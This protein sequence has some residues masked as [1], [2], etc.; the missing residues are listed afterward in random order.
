MITLILEENISEDLKIII[1]IWKIT[2]FQWFSNEVVGW[3]LD[4]DNL[5]SH[6]SFHYFP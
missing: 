4:L 6:P 5:Q 1:F 3:D 2:I